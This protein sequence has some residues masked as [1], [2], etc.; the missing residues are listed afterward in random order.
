MGLHHDRDLA[1]ARRLE[2]TCEELHG[3][4]KYVRRAHINLGHHHKDRDAQS[5]G[6]AKMFLGHANNTSIGANLNDRGNND[7]IVM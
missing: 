1:T 7:A 3:L 5:K 2:D 6:Q 4:L